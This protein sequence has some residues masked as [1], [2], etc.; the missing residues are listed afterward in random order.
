MTGAR[1]KSV[2]PPFL[3]RGRRSPGY[4]L[5]PLPGVRAAVLAGVVAVVGIG[6]APTGGGASIM[7][8]RYQHVTVTGASGTRF[9]VKNDNFGGHPECLANQDGKANF[10]V[11]KSLRLASH[12]KVQA[13][14]FIMLG[15]SWGTCS[16]GGELPR[17]ISSLSQPGVSWQTTQKAGGTWDSAFDIWFGKRS[18]RTGQANGELMIWLGERNRPVPA[19]AKVVT[20]EHTRW[21]VVHARPCY[22]GTCWSYVQFRRVRP[23]LAVTDLPLAPFISRAE[24]HG[25]IKPSWWLENIEAGFEIWDG[26]TGLATRSFGARP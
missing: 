7:C 20:V 17:R 8:H 25:W 24:A 15:C 6:H 11:T 3:V 14:P 19:R 21:Y 10:T 16:P 26:G 23:V 4:S 5:L 18:M 1:E 2:W 12:K 9:L 22:N 13:Y